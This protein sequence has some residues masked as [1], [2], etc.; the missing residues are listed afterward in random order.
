MQGLLRERWH[1]LWPILALAGAA[2]VSGAVAVV[3]LAAPAKPRA[4]FLRVADPAWSP[5]ARRIVFAATDQRGTDAVWTLYVMD[6][7]GGGVRRL[8]GAAFGAKSPSW[9]PDGRSIAFSH[10]DPGFGFPRDEDVH[11]IR[12]DGTGMR[13]ILSDASDPAWSPR[14]KRIAYAY[15]APNFYQHAIMTVDPDGRARRLV[16]RPTPG[17]GEGGGPCDGYFEPTWSPDGEFIAFSVQGV[18]LGVKLF[19]LRTRRLTHLRDGWHAS[20][21]RDG[22]RLVFV[23]GSYLDRSRIY[24]MNADGSNLRQLTH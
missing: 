12:P 3:A 18:P 7:D 13:R 19:D 2:A 11:V 6:A 17:G 4:T 16:A 14:G 5:D 24:A 8:T 15:S 22:T 9:S 10:T 21:S 1:S 23:R 20:W